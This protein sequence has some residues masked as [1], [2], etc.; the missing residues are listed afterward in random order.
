MKIM[1]FYPRSTPPEKVKILLVDDDQDDFILTR[2]L[3]NEVQVIDFEIEWQKNYQTARQS[4]I[5]NHYDVI[6]ID[7]RLGQ[8]NGL[9]LLKEVLSA[10][11]RSPIILLTGQ[12]DREVDLDAMRAGAADY[13]DKNNL[14]PALLERSI[15]YA[16]EKQNLINSLQEA[17]EKIKTLSGLIPI[18][19]N[20]KKI[21]DD[22][23]YW[24]TLET[25]I[26]KHSLAEFSHGLCPDCLK[27][28]YPDLHQTKEDKPKRK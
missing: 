4:I 25:Y 12:G 10:G 8:E 15:R 28:L 1:P 17:L 9:D 14:T 7:Y 19:A 2:E 20:C 3:L 24:N 23:G 5:Q 21:R 22:K 6:L 27:K 16:I 11:C 13:L 18:C 26:E